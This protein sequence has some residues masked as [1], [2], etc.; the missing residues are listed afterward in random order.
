M[1]SVSFYQEQQDYQVALEWALCAEAKA[2]EQFG[3]M[4]T[5]YVASLTEIY[6]SYYMGK[7]DKAIEYCEKAK[8]IIKKLRGEESPEYAEVVG[9]LICDPGRI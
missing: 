1:D 5:N 6:L 2:K 8:P 4:D 7:A 3:E 9:N